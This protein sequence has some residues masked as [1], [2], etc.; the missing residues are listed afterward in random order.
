M[1]ASLHLGEQAS[2]MCLL[3]GDAGNG[4]IA[5]RVPAEVDLRTLMADWEGLK[6]TLLADGGQPGQ[7][8]LRIAPAD[9]GYRDLYI[10]LA[11]DLHDHLEQVTQ[12]QEAAKVL[13]SRLR[14]WAGFLRRGGRPLDART[15]RGL[16]AELMA[17]EQLL[18]PAIGWEAALNAWSGPSGT[19]Q[20]V[21]TDRLA[22]D[23]KA[24]RQDDAIV[25]I[26]SIEQLDPPGSRT[27]RL[28][29][30]VVSEGHGETLATLVSRLNT[31][32]G[33]AGCAPMFLA[34]LR[35]MQITPYG[36]Q[37]TD[38]QPMTL[39]QW[40]VHRVDDPGFPRLMR[41][42]VPA[43][44]VSASYRIDLARSTAPPGSLEEIT[45]MLSPSMS[46]PLAGGVQ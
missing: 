22:M 20:D 29:E 28:L 32:A 17:L 4:E 10:H 1:R 19:A 11:D 34:R 37:D 45:E 24:S 3:G 26:S 27:V 14:L 38:G 39:N 13:L 21:I 23:V 12:P 43:G 25:T 33:A 6:V 44:L 46:T 35:Q 8:L 40:R 16:F 36:L 2:L 30:G 15:I 7:H 31:S 41:S 18:I 9:E 42:D 5:L